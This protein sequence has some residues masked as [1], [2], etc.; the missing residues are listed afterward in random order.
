MGP[1]IPDLPLVLPFASLT[2]SLLF[3]SNQDLLATQVTGWCF[4]L[5]CQLVPQREPSHLAE[6]WDALPFTCISELL[7]QAA[8]QERKRP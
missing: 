8:L 6:G 1:K 5:S 3:G 2:V 4:P 7:K